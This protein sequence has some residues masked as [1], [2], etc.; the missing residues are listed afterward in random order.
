MF[1]PAAIFTLLHQRLLWRVMATT[2]SNLPR[3]QNAADLIV[4]NGSAVF[5]GRRTVLIA[6]ARADIR[7]SLR[8]QLSAQGFAVFATGDA[9]VALTWVARRTADLVISDV[10][11]P[12]T[13]TAIPHVLR[14]RSRSHLRC[15][16]L[17]GLTEDMTSAA[18]LGQLLGYDVVLRDRTPAA[19]VTKQALRLVG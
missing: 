7:W 19:V 2:T 11:L 5:G 1:F 18:E 12:G 4:S 6:V 10:L 16:K 17:I 8:E 15:P 13:R 3:T 9:Q 14:R